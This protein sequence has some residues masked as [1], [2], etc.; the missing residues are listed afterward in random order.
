MAYYFDDQK[1]DHRPG[2]Y[3]V[4]IIDGSRSSLLLGPFPRHM[5]A[6]LKV[7]AVRRKAVEIDAKAHFYA[8]GTAR[9]PAED[10]APIGR[11]NDLF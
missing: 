8:F 4:S 6:L 9:V 1:I 3:Y 2:H 5:T 7:S 10:T 11:L